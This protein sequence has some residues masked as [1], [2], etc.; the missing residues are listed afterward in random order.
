MF[1]EKVFDLVIETI[2]YETNGERK[3]GARRMIMTSS[4]P[5]FDAIFVV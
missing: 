1:G 4:F 3:L 5:F 2:R